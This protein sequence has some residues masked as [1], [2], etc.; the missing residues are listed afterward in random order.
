MEFENIIFIGQDLAY[1]S[2]GKSHPKD[3]LYDEYC[4]SEFEK[5]NTLAYNGKG[6]V[7]THITWDM[8][9]VNLQHLF[10]LSK[11]KIYNATEGGAR[12]EGSIEQPFKKL[13]EDLLK[14]K[15]D[16]NFKKL[17]NLKYTKK[18][19]YLLKTY[20]QINLLLKD[21]THYLQKYTDMI[22]FI[23]DNFNDFSKIIQFLDDLDL[24]DFKDN[25]LIK[26][27]L[28]CYLD[29]MRFA[30]AKIYIIIPNDENI[31]LQKN[32]AWINLHLEYFQLIVITLES[33]KNL[34]L[35]NKKIIENELLKNHLEK[36][37]KN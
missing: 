25:E 6:F 20:H 10:T 29:Q 12:I 35:Q 22:L 21:I 14:E 4:D 36:Y 32:Q 9:R 23:K 17:D 24:D 13:C 26:L 19:E 1:D 31:L 28:A 11:A 30:L 18:Q 16:K 3:Y 8:F 7:K 27:L 34:I 37:I 2:N 33:L 15:I 5:F